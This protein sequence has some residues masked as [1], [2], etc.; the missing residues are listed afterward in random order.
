MMRSPRWISRLILPLILGWL[1]T[2]VWSDP[3]G[4]GL[5]TVPSSLARSVRG[6][7]RPS[8]VQL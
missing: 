2:M 5:S 7:E 3:Y 4:D 1:G 8:V 6:W